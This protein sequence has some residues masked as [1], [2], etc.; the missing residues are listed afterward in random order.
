MRLVRTVACSA[1]A[2]A[3]TEEVKFSYSAAELSWMSRYPRLAGWHVVKADIAVLRTPP[4]P[5]KTKERTT[6][7][8][9]PSQQASSCKPIFMRPGSNM[10]RLAWR[11]ASNVHASCLRLYVRS[12]KNFTVSRYNVCGKRI[13]WNHRR[14]PCTGKGEVNTVIMIRVDGDRPG[15]KHNVSLVAWL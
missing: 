13:R 15:E 9:V 1:T 4:A 11:K 3:R 7:R 2:L 8:T 6:Y 10:V 5:V 12:L 14:F